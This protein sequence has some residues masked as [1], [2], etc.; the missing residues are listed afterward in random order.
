MPIS[1]E[2][3]CINKSGCRRNK[4]CP[5]GGVHG[6]FAARCNR[7]PEDIICTTICSTHAEKLGVSERTLYNYIDQRVRN[8]D[9]PKKV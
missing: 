2:N 4:L 3:D 5:I 7:C 1:G 6:C 8:I 9:L